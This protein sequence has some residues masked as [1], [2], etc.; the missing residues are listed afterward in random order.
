MEEL[1]KKIDI[2]DK[3]IENALIE[4]FEIVGE[5]GKYK[6]QNNLPIVNKD[7]EKIVFEKIKK[8]TNNKIPDDLIVDIYKTIISCAVKLEK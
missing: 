3:K 1:R 5:I 6:K 8:V 4:R 2:C 7:R